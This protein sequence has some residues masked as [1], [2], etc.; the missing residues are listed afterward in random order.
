MESEDGGGDD[1]ADPADGAD[2][3]DEVD[4]S[5]AV[6]AADVEDA[7]GGLGGAEEADAGDDALGDRGRPAGLVLLTGPLCRLEPAI[8]SISETIHAIPRNDLRHPS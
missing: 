1:P 4:A 3:V 6:D 7:S 8:L 2:E 5:D